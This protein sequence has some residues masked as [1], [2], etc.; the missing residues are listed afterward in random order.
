[1]HTDGVSGI[2]QADGA[3]SGSTAAPFVGEGRRSVSFPDGKEIESV[4]SIE[5]DGV[6]SGKDGD[7]EGSGD[8]SDADPDSELV[9]KGPSL[10]PGTFKIMRRLNQPKEPSDRHP[11]TSGSSEDGAGTVVEPPRLDLSRLPQEERERA[12]AEVRA[13]I[14]GNV[15]A[16]MAEHAKEAAEREQALEQRLD[17]EAEMRKQ[18]IEMQRAQNKWNDM[19]DPAY[20]RG[21]PGGA[22]RGGNNM[23]MGGYPPSMGGHPAARAQGGGPKSPVEPYSGGLDGGGPQLGGQGKGGRRKRGGGGGGQGFGAEG[24]KPSFNNGAD[25]HMQPGFDGGM[26]LGRGGKSSGFD[27]Q[28]PYSGF[29]NQVPMQGFGADAGQMFPDRGK[30]LCGGAGGA[31]SGGG[32]GGPGLVPAANPL[33]FAAW[34]ASAGHAA[35]RGGVFDGTNNS[36]ANFPGADANPWG[37]TWGTPGQQGQN[38][39][40]GLGVG[41]LQATWG[42]PLV[43]APADL[44]RLAA[45]QG[46][47]GV[48]PIQATWGTPDPNQQWN[49]QQ[50]A[51]ASSTQGGPAIH[52]K[53][54]GIRPW[55]ILPPGYDPQQ[56]QQPPPHPNQ[57]SLEHQLQQQQLQQQQQLFLMS[58][59]SAGL[60]AVT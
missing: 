9:D 5:K 60:P 27:H 58:Q 21:N 38:P 54:D 7:M 26:G 33:A 30:N 25:H 49:P 57:Q 12:Y 20:H 48:R 46:G 14:F 36:S 41:Q 59:Q 8:D 53:A 31:W 19:H 4:V 6:A 42:M 32:P 10:V 15:E 29:N 24:G 11:N 34:P 47:L 3:S 16:E 56:Q 40:Q 28:A 39:P 37:R 17:M 23:M 22:G 43:A 51:Y 1:M 55:G 44:S 45:V 52:G 2:I 35:P 50:Q 13:R 18:H